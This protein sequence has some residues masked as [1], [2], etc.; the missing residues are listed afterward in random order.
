MQL[1]QSLQPWRDWLQWFP[2]EQLPLLAD[3]FARLNPLLGPLRGMQQ[4]GVP[5]PDGLGDLQRRGPYERLLASEWLLADELPDE[6]LRRA[7]VGEHLFLAP[8][9]RTHQANRMIVVLFDAGPLQLGVPRLV[10]LALLILLARRASEAGA[11]LRWGILQNAPQLHEFKGAAHLKQLLDARTYQTVNDEHWQTWRAWLSEQDYDSGERWVVGHQLPATDARSCTHRVQIQRSLDGRS[12]MFALQDLGT[13]QV[14]LPNPDERLALQLIKGEFDIA[15][16]M[17][18]TAVKTPIPRV[19]LTL[20]PIIATSGSHVALKLLDEPGLVVIKLPAPRQKKPLDVRRTLWNNRSTPLAI[21]FP[22]RMPGA[23]LSL[24]EQLVFW[25]MPGLKPAARPEREQLQMP[26][27]TATLLPMVWLHNGTYG[28]VFLL[29]NKGHLAFWVVDNGKLPTPHQPGITHSMADQVVDMAQVDRNM[30][31]YLRHDTGRLYVHRINPWISQSAGHVVGTAKD[32]DVDQV[33]FPASPLWERAFHGCAWMRLVDE[34]QQWQMV[35]PDLQTSQVDLA[36]GWKGLGLLIGED[37]VLSMVLLG[38]N[39]QTVALYCRGEQHVLFT[40]SEAIARISF[41][42]MSGLVAALTKARELVV[43]SV[44]DERR[45]LQVICNQA[46][47]QS[48]DAPHVR[49]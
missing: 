3:L 24:D 18:R 34:K 7:V 10:H 43:Y 17:A 12:L 41:C 49:T 5:E 29:D 27:G 25:N 21:T 2:P 1:P 32:V 40:T 48:E 9:Y 11:E 45:V 37:E 28:R 22:G 31:A 16:Q 30:L 38:P 46:Q 20:A 6:F 4:G 23:I 36:P 19:A 8:Q 26:V 39:Q 33:L 35:A 44:R 14:A 13:R 42:P 47:T 15:R